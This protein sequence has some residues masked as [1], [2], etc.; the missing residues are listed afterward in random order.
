M[1]G[2][3]QASNITPIASSTVFLHNESSA[4]VPPPATITPTPMESNDRIAAPPGIIFR[5]EDGIW[6]IR[7]DGSSMYLVPNRRAIFSP[8][9]QYV[10][11]NGIEDHYVLD[12]S[13]GKIITEFNLWD[14]ENDPEMEN[15]ERLYGATWSRDS[16]Y[17]YYCSGPS[18]NWY[19]DIWSIEIL[20]GKKRNLSNTEDRSE[21]IPSLFSNDNML[22]FPS[23]ILEDPYP[24]SS[25]YLTSV[26]I[27]GSDY[28]IYSEEND[29][30]YF[31]ISPDGNTA[32]IFG[33][34]LFTSDYDIT[35]ITPILNDEDHNLDFQ[36]YHPA[37][38][39]DSETI[40][41][42]VGIDTEQI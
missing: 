23:H 29:K 21:G 30:G 40:G 19:T 10:L 13:T 14:S 31:R 18:G 35:R 32:A 41:W 12:L 37:W 20:T 8:N 2:C 33:E 28:S 11:F 42:G 24:R 27:D 34:E 15:P 25:G 4:T 17:V 22:M 38:S 7:L 39:S 6:A 16:T 3:T 1:V 36:L 26:A 9:Y 5:S